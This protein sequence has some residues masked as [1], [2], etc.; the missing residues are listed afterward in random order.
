M[1]KYLRLRTP[2]TEEALP[3]RDVVE[4]EAGAP[5]YKYAGMART[6][7]ASLACV[8]RRARRGC[9]GRPARRHLTADRVCW[10]RLRGIE[11]D[12]VLAPGWTSAEHFSACVRGHLTAALSA[13]RH[14]RAG[15]PRWWRLGL[16]SVA[17]QAV[18]VAG[19]AEARQRC[20]A[21]RE[22]G[23]GTVIYSQFWQLSYAPNPASWS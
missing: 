22:G 2:S 8:V 21:S 11:R 6:E 4:S 14:T 17:E 18:V 15:P 19:K 3:G 1:S 13:R 20:P 10:C 9:V 5:G 16:L 7:S 12:R 23:R